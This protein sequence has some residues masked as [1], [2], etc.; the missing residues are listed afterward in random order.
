MFKK[1]DPSNSYKIKTRKEVLKNAEDLF[2]IR[3]RIIM[4]F[5]DGTFPLAKDVQEKQTKEVN[6]KWLHRPKNE[7]ESVIEEIN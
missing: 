1:C 7:L 3:N 5:E 6:F 2:K 4:A